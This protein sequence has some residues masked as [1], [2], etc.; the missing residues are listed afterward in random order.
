MEKLPLPLRATFDLTNSKLGGQDLSK[1]RPRY[2]Y[3]Q[4]KSCRTA[5]RYD[6][7]NAE[8]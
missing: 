1:P 4:E 8:S 2:L 6:Y 3:S 7:Y 5:G